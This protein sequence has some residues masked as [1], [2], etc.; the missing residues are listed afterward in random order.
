MNINKINKRH[1]LILL[2][3]LYLISN[4]LLLFVHGIFW[5]DWT[6][7]HDAKAIEQQFFQGNGA[8][9]FGYIH[10]YLQGLTFNTILL[11]RILI[12]LIGWGCVLSFY[13]ILKTSF[14]IDISASFYIAA[15]YATFPLGYA[16]MT[17][18]CLPYQIGLLLQLIAIQLFY[19]I[20]DKFNI[21]SYLLFFLI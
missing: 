9:I 16:H 12:L 4:I 19:S 11:Y 17:M 10:L 15:L 5:D 21:A 13:K 18:I 8:I 14:K 7:Y 2:S 1:S 20:K 3:I 6:L